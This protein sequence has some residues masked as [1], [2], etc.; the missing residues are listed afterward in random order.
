[1]YG[2]YAGDTSASPAQMTSLTTAQDGVSTSAYT[3]SDTFY[4]SPFMLWKI[5]GLCNDL[6]VES[7]FGLS[8]M[9]GHIIFI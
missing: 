2:K 9:G 6:S 7:S 8:I 4:I 3:G 1:M 5:Y